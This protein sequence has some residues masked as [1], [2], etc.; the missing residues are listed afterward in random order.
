MSVLCAFFKVGKVE[1]KTKNDECS[2]YM[3]MYLLEE[4][5]AFM[6]I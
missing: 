2:L 5:V 6:P 4:K 3:Y 1:I